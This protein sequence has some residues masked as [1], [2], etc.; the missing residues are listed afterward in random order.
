MRYD[1][2]TKTDPQGTQEPQNNPIFDKI[3]LPKTAFPHVKPK[4]SNII[5]G[6]LGAFLGSIISCTLWIVLYNQN[7]DYIA[8][9]SWVVR[10]AIGIIALK[11]Y[12]LLGKCLDIK[13][14]II[15]FLIIVVMIF[16]TNKLIWS[17]DVYK[18]Y[19]DYTWTFI[20]IFNELDM[21]LKHHELTSS[22][23]TDLI[24]TYVFTIIA[25]VRFVI[26]KFKI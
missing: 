15:T 1:I 2:N 25:S 24:T 11:G 13:G 3:N 9:L 12:E 8:G 14:V 16:L 10:I 23:Y 5:T 17:L 20:E 19:K 26:I 7:L 4:K 6:V 22:Y 18:I 21:I